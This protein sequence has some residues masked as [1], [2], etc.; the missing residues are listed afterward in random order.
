MNVVQYAVRR[1]LL[2]AVVLVGVTLVTFLVSHLVPGDPVAAHLGQRA[3]SDPA[4]VEAFRARWGLDRPLWEQYWLYLKGLA[5]GDLGYS[6]SSHRPVA[7]DLAQYLPATFEL[8]TC[9]IVVSFLLG[10]PFGIVSA[11]KRNRPVDHLLRA[12]SV[13]GVSVP[14]FWLALLC[15]YV[16]YFV[17]DLVPGAGRLSPGLSLR[18]P[19]GLMVLDAILTRRWDVLGDALSHLVMPALVLGSASMGLVTRTTR[20]SFLEVTDQDYLRTARAKGVPERTVIYRH[21]LRNALIPVVT[22]LGLTYG[23]LLGGTV[24]VETIF[25]W[26]GVGRY[27]FEA[28]VSLD[29]PAIMGVA[30][31]VAT[32]YTAANLVVDVAYSWLDPRVRLR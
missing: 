10:V 5:H 7:Q 13:F 29:F 28:A 17:L 12:V 24:L 3:M 22:I 4:I 8:A 11:I 26:P 25:A 19:T 18:G 32:V 31:L 16:F 9:A 14:A 6:I 1:L 23:S 27:A 21:A 15:L 20:S 2:A 30:I